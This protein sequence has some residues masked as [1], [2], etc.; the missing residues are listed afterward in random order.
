MMVRAACLEEVMSKTMA[1]MLAVA[2]LCMTGCASEPASGKLDAS[3]QAARQVLAGFRN[4]PMKEA[5]RDGLRKA[6]AILIVSPGVDRGVVLVRG[7]EQEW[8]GPVFYRITRLETAGGTTGGTGFTVG[9]QD[10][11]LIAL[12]M[13]DKGVAWFMSPRLPGQSGLNVWHATHASGGSRKAA[14]MVLFTRSASGNPT[15]RVA[16]IDLNSTI[17]SI[18]KEGNQA[19]YGRPVTPAEILSM[20]NAASPD[21]VSLRDAVASAAQ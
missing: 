17:I 21:A 14:D 13:T 1:G 6:R 10:L 18:D 4:D 11:E 12:A 2:F 19:Y 3:V 9:K 8:R 7:N 16:R 5:L 15:G 20:Q